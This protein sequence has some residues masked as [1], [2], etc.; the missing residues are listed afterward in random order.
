MN[1]T[2]L[3]RRFDVMMANV[4]DD[5]LVAEFESMGYRDYKELDT[6]SSAYKEIVKHFKKLGTHSASV[7]SH[8]DMAYAPQEWQS[9]DQ[10]CEGSNKITTTKEIVRF[11]RLQ[12][13]SEGASTSDELALA[14]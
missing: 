14:A 10:R 4:T 9:F 11:N 5:E 12:A 7:F 3:R 13:K 2:E 1:A 8:C 6:S